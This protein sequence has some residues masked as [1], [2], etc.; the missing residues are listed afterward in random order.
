[1]P[2]RQ[3]HVKVGVFSGCGL[4]AYRSREQDLLKMFLETIGGGFGGYIGSKLPDIIEPASWPGHRQ[5][6]HSVTAGGSIACLYGLLERW[7]KYFRS[8]AKY[9]G[10]KKSEECVCWFQKFLYVIFEVLSCI[11][12]GSLGGLGAGYISHLVLDGRTAK[13]LP[14]I[15]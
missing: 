6:A 3:V 5:F 1:M 9:Y 8:Q 4:A 10:D 7:E 2:N 13:G 14:V 15:N 11:L 12:A